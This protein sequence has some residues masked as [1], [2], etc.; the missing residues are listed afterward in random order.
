MRG[1]GIVPPIVHEVL[2]SAGQ[3]LD[4]ATRALFEPRFGQDFSRVRVHTDA[5]AAQSARAVNALA[6][7]V[8]NDVSFADNQY[9][10]EKANGRTL[11]A[12]ELTHVIQQ[13]GA[14]SSRQPQG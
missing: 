10:P 3:P 5:K 14:G 6:Y 9:A 7:T 12:H 11:I 2:R 8:G 13:S 1:E 4:V